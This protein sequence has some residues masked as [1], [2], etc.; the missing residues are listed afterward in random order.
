MWLFM[1]DFDNSKHSCVN[2]HWNIVLKI[3]FFSSD[4]WRLDWQSVEVKR[5]HMIAWNCPSIIKHYW[6]ECIE[7][8]SVIAV[9]QLN[10]HYCPFRTSSRRFAFDEIYWRF[11]A[12]CVNSA[13]RR[14]QA[15]R[16]LSINKKQIIWIRRC[17]VIRLLTKFQ[18]F[19]DRNFVFAFHIRAF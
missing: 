18:P 4:W 8:A 16:L 12:E 6:F 17:F 5:A 1:F 10:E 3:V 15:R 7:W 2:L 13:I 9:T 19:Q 14:Y 11:Y